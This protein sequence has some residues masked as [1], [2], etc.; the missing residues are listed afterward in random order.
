M[1]RRSLAAGAGLL[2]LLLL[3]LAFK[4][5]LNSRKERAF[6]DYAGEVTALV[7]ESRQQSDNL[8]QL[9]SDPGNA[10]DVDIANQLNAFRVQAQ[11]LVVRARE[12]DHPD[13]LN[14]AQ[15]SLVE[16]LELRRDGVNA[17]ADRLPTAIANRQ[18]RRNGTETIARSMQSF[19]ASDVIYQTRVVPRLRA[20]L[21]SE[22]LEEERV[23]PSQFL[24][25]IDWL[26][27]DFV[28][29]NVRKLGGKGG[30]A[31]G[32]AAPGLHGTGVAGA[33]LGG[34]ALTPGG[35]A[36]IAATGDLKLVVQVANQGENTETD[37][38]VNV[39]IGRGGD[40]I[41]LDKVLDTIAA[42]ETK[43]VEIPVTER[44]P[45]GQ[46]VPI[47]VDVEPVPGEK[48]TDNN[49]GSFSAIFTR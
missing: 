8:F 5:C 29:S 11:Q 32:D 20:E 30:G 33:T 18:D 13:E 28:A 25:V 21:K 9:L 3:F 45:T 12:T 40:A 46:N 19:L 38:K 26:R 41:E 23:P 31:A 47:S 4:G 17:I 2:A 49:K 24:P 48:K 39:K 35:A 1:V 37:V 10:T 34:Q 14:T 7:G 43:S 42:G 6:K 15:G 27:P 22:G 44:P 16:T 36:S